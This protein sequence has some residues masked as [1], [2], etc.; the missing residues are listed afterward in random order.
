MSRLHRLRALEA[1]L[2]PPRFI[3]L[4]FEKPDRDR[5]QAIMDQAGPRDTVLIVYTGVSDDFP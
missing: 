3:L 4:A 5:D 2:G 1:R